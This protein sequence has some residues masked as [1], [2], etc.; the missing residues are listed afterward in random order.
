MKPIAKDE[1]YEHLNQFLKARG[2]ELKEGSYSKQI[3]RGCTLLADTINLSQEGIERAKVGIERNLDRMRQ[4]IHERT[5]PKAKASSSASAKSEKA[6]PDSSA[7]KTRPA[8][9]LKPRKA[10]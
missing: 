2:I 6:A 8:R 10:V 3:Q 5:A 4:V 7:K 9:R 1:L